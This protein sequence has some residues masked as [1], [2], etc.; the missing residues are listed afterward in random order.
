MLGIRLM[1]R[2]APTWAFGGY[3]PLCA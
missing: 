3:S 1:V 2:W